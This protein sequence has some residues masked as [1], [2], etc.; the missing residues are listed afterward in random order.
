MS[1]PDGGVAAVRTI[2]AGAVALVITAGSAYADGLPPPAYEPASYSWSDIYLGVNGGYG[3]ASSPDSGISR[4]GAIAGGQI[5][6]NWQSGK[7][8]VGTEVDLQW[9]GQKSENAVLVC[10]AFSCGPFNI[11]GAVDDFAT[12]GSE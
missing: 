5:G 3:W 11:T 9:S 6:L 4:S 1:H 2:T 7:L 8:V 10:G 12:G